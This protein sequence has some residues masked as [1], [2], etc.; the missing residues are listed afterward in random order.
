[1]RIHHPRSS[2]L[3]D[4]EVVSA[5]FGLLSLSSHVSPTFLSA[6]RQRLMEEEALPRPPT[7]ALGHLVGGP[8]LS[9]AVRHL[10]SMRSAVLGR[11]VHP[12]AQRF[13]SF[14]S[15]S[16]IFGR[17]SESA[18]GRENAR[19]E[20]TSAR[21]RAPGP[22]RSPPGP[23]CVCQNMSAT[24]S[25]NALHCEIYKAVHATPLVAACRVCVRAMAWCW[26][27][28]CALAAAPPA[29]AGGAP[30]GHTTR[31]TT[32]ALPHKIVIQKQSNATPTVAVWLEPMRLCN[33][34]A[35]YAYC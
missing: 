5:D 6:Y 2:T 17:V 30:R 28:C 32:P 3:D 16:I 14:L 11:L 9:W 20:R 4:F 29:R 18:G 19:S 23:A 27:C 24:L 15:G 22:G 25:F 31:G 34:Y 13:T 21:A 12:R 35:V 26:G 8:Y 10:S 33:V 7:P 1:M